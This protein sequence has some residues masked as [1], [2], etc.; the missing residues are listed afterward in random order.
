MNRNPI[1]EELYAAR[2]KLLAKAGGDIRRY[3]EELRRR[4]ASDRLLPLTPQQIQNGGT[5]QITDLRGLGKEIWK[6]VDADE[7]VAKERDS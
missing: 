1:L 6:G 5:H 4:A 7:Y 3:L 2:D